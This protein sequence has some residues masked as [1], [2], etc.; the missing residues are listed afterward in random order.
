MPIDNYGLWEQHNAKAEAWLEKQPICVCCGY[1]IQDDFLFDINGDL[2]C[3][4]CMKDNF[5][6]CTDDYVKGE[7]EDD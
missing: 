7:Y 1:H 6:K 4:E 5:R 2:F 3:E